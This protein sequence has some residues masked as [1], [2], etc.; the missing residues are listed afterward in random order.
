MDY[1]RQQL[2]T[3]QEC[4]EQL[5]MVIQTTGNPLLTQGATAILEQYESLQEEDYKRYCREVLEGR[6]PTQRLKT[7]LG[8]KGTPPPN[9]L[10]PAREGDFR[11]LSDI[12]ELIRA[13]LTP[14]TLR[15]SGYGTWDLRELIKD[16]PGFPSTPDYSTRVY[17][18]RCPPGRT[19]VYLVAKLPTKELPGWVIWYIS[20]IEHTK[21]L[22]EVTFRTYHPG[23]KEWITHP[24]SEVYEYTDIRR[25]LRALLIQYGHHPTHHPL[26]FTA[27]TRTLAPL[28][29]QVPI[30]V[31][32][33]ECVFVASKAPLGWE[34]TFKTSKGEV[35][36]W[37]DLTPG[38]Q[39]ALV[40]RLS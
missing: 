37:E 25:A 33:N 40:A 17:R 9:Y 32:V 7:K 28:E 31:E 20:D 12:V 27:L 18:G 29:H 23:E 34:C 14:V 1:L 8:I 15:G 6:G 36:N 10:N 5:L 11:P 21:P 30:K 35:K 16:A 13:T 22:V 38:T 4:V 39:H 24:H 26:P 3:T 19:P 2:K